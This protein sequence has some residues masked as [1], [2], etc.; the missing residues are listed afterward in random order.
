MN[1]W[2]VWYLV[3]LLLTGLGYFL[4]GLLV[5][6]GGLGLWLAYALLP[7][8]WLAALVKP[9]LPNV[10][11]ESSGYLWFLIF[12]IQMSFW[13]AVGRVVLRLQKRN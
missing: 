12:V 1:F 4:F 5:H 6:S 2:T 9:F 13:Y 8:M 10:F 11:I 7:G 3:G